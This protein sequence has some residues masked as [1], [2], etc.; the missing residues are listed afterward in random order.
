MVV[1]SLVSL[2]GDE[3]G[4]TFLQSRK[5]S[6]FSHVLVSSCQLHSSSA[7]HHGPVPGIVAQFARKF[8][9]QWYVANGAYAA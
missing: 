1:V 5:N 9:L 6:L 4:V 7:S 2:W 8:R 3:H